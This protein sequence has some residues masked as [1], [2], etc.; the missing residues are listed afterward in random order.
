MP[1]DH[2]IA[3]RL[4]DAQTAY[5]KAAAAHALA[6]RIG[7]AAEREATG[8]AS[9]EAEAAYD[10]AYAEYEAAWTAARAS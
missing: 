5:H 4:V 1:I 3:A 10:A 9:D 8:R 6:D 2:N 7:T